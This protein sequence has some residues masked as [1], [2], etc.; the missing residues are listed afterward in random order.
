MN[1]WTIRAVGSKDAGFL[2]VLMNDPAVMARLHQ[3]PTRKQDWEDAIA[4]W[5][6]DAD[7]EGYIIR[8]G[9]RDIGWFAVNALASADSVPY[10][11]IAVLLPEF[12]NRGLGRQIIQHLMDALRK[13]GYPAV[14]LFVDQD[15]HGARRCYETCGFQAVGTVY[16][17]WP[18]GTTCTQLE[19]EANTIL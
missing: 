10:I 8:S 6:Q 12:Q 13:R 2:T 14:R 3:A 9:Q 16:Q 11:K 15:N 4:L 18:D 17:Q 7:E 5:L 1:N 19:M